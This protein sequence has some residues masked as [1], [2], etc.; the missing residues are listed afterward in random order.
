M[1]FLSE[2]ELMTVRH[3]VTELTGGTR[4]ASLRL[5]AGIRMADR[6]FAGG[7]GACGRDMSS[8]AAGADRILSAVFSYIRG[9]FILAVY[10]TSAKCLM[11]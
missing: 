9:G 11:L 10:A 1:K 7:R 2:G 4:V 6:A 5:R 3:F 8:H